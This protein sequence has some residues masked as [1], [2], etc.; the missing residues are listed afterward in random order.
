MK[1]ALTANGPGEVAGWVRP[2]LRRVYEREPAAE[3]HVFLVPDA[4]AT[5]HEAAM[6]RAAFP[7]AHVYEARHWVKFALGGTIDGGPE[8]VDAVQYLGGDLMHAARLHARLRGRAAT[9]KFS[10]RRYRRLFDR[11]FAVDERNERDLEA[12]GTPPSR[13]VRVGNLAI[14]GALLES[15]AP[16]EAGS[17]HDGILIMPGSRG[18]EIEHLVPFFFTAALTI[19]RERPSVPVAFGISPFTSVAEL[20]SAIEGAGDPRV[21]A[22][23]GRLVERGAYPYFES[24]DGDVR[25]PIVRNALAAAARA[26][27]AL[28]LPGTKCI[29][30][31][32]LGVPTV[33]VTP[34]NAAELVTFN[35]PLTYLDRLPV[36]GRALKRQV[37]VGI[38]RR[39]RFHTQPNM[40]ANEMLVWELHGTLT[41]GRVARV[42][43]E[44]YDDADWLARTGA[45][46]RELYREHSGASD[47]MAASLVDLA[48]S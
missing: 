48:G 30:L 3:A 13:I 31:A 1:L 45:R 47:R 39:F 6:L 16:L 9:Y 17:P 18:Y 19:A 44:R 7:Q 5:G 36:A 43:L 42:A 21:Y 41:P 20:R 26:R 12:C 11:A 4:Y 2:L 22:R 35:G 24:L 25:V 28:T 46:L 32:S 37:A 38:S 14:D 8:R 40:D 33:T 15:Q 23:P 29:E 10:K 34:I 27:L